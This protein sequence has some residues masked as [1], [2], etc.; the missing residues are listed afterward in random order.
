MTCSV[1]CVDMVLVNK[2]AIKYMIV[3]DFAPPLVNNVEHT[4]LDINAT[5]NLYRELMP[6]IV[7][8]ED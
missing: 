1:L 8:P 7:Q 2:W 3:F 4:K 6:I 5:I